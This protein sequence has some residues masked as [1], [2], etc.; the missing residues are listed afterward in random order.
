MLFGQALTVDR[1]QSHLHAGGQ[2]SLLFLNIAADRARQRPEVGG[3]HGL[4]RHQGLAHAFLQHFL[5]VRR[6]GVSNA[7]VLFFLDLKPCKSFQQFRQL[8]LAGLSHPVK[9]VAHGLVDNPIL[10]QLDSVILVQGQIAGKALDQ[11]VGETVQRHHRHFAVSVKHGGPQC[12][13]AAGK[14]FLGQVGL[15][16]ELAEEILGGRPS[17]HLRQIRQNPLFH[18]PSGFVGEG[19]RQHMSESPW[20]VVHQAAG[21][22]AADQP[23]RLAASGRC[24]HHFKGLRRFHWVMG[25]VSSATFGAN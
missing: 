9:H 2:F 1:I 5:A 4:E 8:F 6:Q 23:V 7:A 17:T 22:I 15:V 14:D 16:G 11:S 13:G 20:V 10:V 3:R 25:C 12:T 24:T 19:Q 21:Q 18:F